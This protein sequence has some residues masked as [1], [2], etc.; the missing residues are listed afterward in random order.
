MSPA[1]TQEWSQ[2]TGWGPS[3]GFDSGHPTFAFGELAFVMGRAGCGGQAHR[4]GKHERVLMGRGLSPASN[5][6]QRG[7]GPGKEGAVLRVGVGD[8]RGGEVPP[9][10]L[11]LPVLC[12]PTHTFPERGALWEM[13]AMW[14]LH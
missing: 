5:R 14:L 7:K 9:G 6:E 12:P 4:G 10:M 3:R 8:S 13:A 1:P 11:S 2:L